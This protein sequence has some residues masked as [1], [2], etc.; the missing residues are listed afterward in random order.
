MHA[1]W[2]PQVPLAAR[3]RKVKGPT[4]LWANRLLGGS[5]PFWREEY[6]DRTVR[7]RI[8]HYVD[9]NPVRAALVAMPE[10]FMWSG[11]YKSRAGLK[12]RGRKPGSQGRP[13]YNTVSGVNLRTALLR[14][15]R[16]FRL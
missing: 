4:A 1:L 8:R 14:S 15:A 13:G 9:W 6:F 7:N 2:T 12:P 11:A 5:G 3:L 16:V 10:E